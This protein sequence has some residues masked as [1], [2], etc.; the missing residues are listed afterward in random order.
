[1]LGEI[2]KKF[3]LFMLF[4]NVLNCSAYANQYLADDN[5][6]NIL[7]I[8]PPPPARNSA[9]LRLDKSLYIDPLIASKRPQWNEA[10]KTVDLYN[11]DALFSPVVGLTLSEQNTPQTYEL[12]HSLVPL[13]AITLTE[14]T[15]SY[16][17]RK[18]PFDFFGK[19]SCTPALENDLKNNGSYPSGHATTGWALSL[20]LAEIYPERKAEILKRGYELGQFRVICG[21]HWQSDVDAG[22]IAGS[23]AVSALHSDPV[24]MQ[25]LDKAKTEI[26]GKLSDA[27]WDKTLY[28]PTYMAN[29]DGKWFI[30]DCWQSRI[31]WNKTL[32]R[33]LS[34][35]NVMESTFTSHDVA[36]DGEKYW[37][38]EDTEHG[39]MVFYTFNGK[40]FN[41][42]ASLDGLGRRTHRLRFDKTRNQFLLISATTGDFWRISI[43]KDKPE[44]R[45][46][47]ILPYS[48]KNKTNDF[49]IRS[50]T[51][52]DNLIYFVSSMA[53][54]EILVTKNDEKLTVVKSI[55]VSSDFSNMQ[56]IYFLNDGKIF[57]SS[58]YK[59]VA[60]IDKI[61]DLQTVKNQYNDFEFL[62]SPYWITAF[63]GNL[64]IPEIGYK[65]NNR[66]NYGMNGVGLW[67]YNKGVLKKLKE[68]IPF[69]APSTGNTKMKNEIK[70]QVY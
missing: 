26:H 61:E 24:F 15:K 25:N 30:V 39:R 70:F 63:Q 28:A 62:G 18:R 67:S 8:L 2:V 3:F 69:T 14:K 51:L 66:E 13:L 64:I 56:E 65:T 27:S 33:D 4:L 52:R 21:V 37:A 1:M 46:H 32:D 59:K 58:D 11:I 6:P 53:T 29:I 23:I 55:P 48:L 44:I 45:S 12:L 50:F 38:V 20:I 36:Y 31:I 42:I 9:Q 17:H 47:A 22:R 57:I 43:N 34:K 40:K 7:Y 54:P 49:E 10:K 68:I 35:W 41:E 60:I 5:L 16:Y 19:H